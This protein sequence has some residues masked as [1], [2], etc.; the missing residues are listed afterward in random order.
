MARDNRR[1]LLVALVLAAAM[2]VVG[3][4]SMSSSNYSTLDSVLDA[5]KRVK[6]TVEAETA[7]LGEGAYMLIVGDKH[8][9]VEAH[10][11]YGVAWDEEGNVYAVFLLRGEE[12]LALALYPVGDDIMAYQT[13]AGLQARVV[14]TGVYDPSVKAVLV[15]PQAGSVELPLIQV[16][17]ILKGCHTSYQQEA[18]TIG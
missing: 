13:G 14:I 6:V 15:S 12:S 1:V 10:G 16:D 8:Y 5:N 4:T 2:A 3:Y 11:S 7:S 18:A 9:T 17:A